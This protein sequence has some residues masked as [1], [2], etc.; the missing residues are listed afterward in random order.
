MGITSPDAIPFPDPG[1]AFTPLETHFANLADGA[2]RA[3]SAL[4]GATAPPVASAAARNTLYPQPAQG[5]SVYRMDY[6]WEERYF[7]EYSAQGNPGGATPAGWY[8]VGGKMPIFLMD[9]A[10]GAD[11]TSPTGWT[12]MSTVFAGT[13]IFNHGF[14]AYS[15]GALTV[16]QGGTYEVSGSIQTPGG[17]T[18]GIQ[19]TRNT[20]SADT[21]NTLVNQQVQ[22]SG[23]PTGPNG[24]RL[25]RLAAGD[26]IRM[27]SVNI[28][29][30]PIH[31]GPGQ[32]TFQVMYV[33]PS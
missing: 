13:P 22:E 27:L 14:T 12:P 1:T 18:K 2:Q 33:G 20:S 24:S 3:I 15:T 25:A 26:V 31:R 8:P 21:G 6:G 9:A 29:E 4:R 16:M 5:N 32:T 23:G 28:P 17:G 7:A 11:Q 10:N 30:A 19:I